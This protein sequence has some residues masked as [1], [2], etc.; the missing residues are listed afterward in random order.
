MLRHPEPV[1]AQR[2]D[3]HR[4]ITAAAQGL[5]FGRAGGNGGEV[6]NLLESGRGRG[7]QRHMGAALYDCYDRASRALLPHATRY[8]CEILIL[9]LNYRRVSVI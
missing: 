4:E 2:F 6:K 1:I 3:V 7:H 9:C 5:G 8:G